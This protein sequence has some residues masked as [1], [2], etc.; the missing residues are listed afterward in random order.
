MLVLSDQAC[1]DGQAFI[2]IICALL[3]LFKVF[4]RFFKIN[5]LIKK[6]SL[7]ESTLQKGAPTVN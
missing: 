5:K 4:L 3:K 7:S 1:W 2:K 6:T